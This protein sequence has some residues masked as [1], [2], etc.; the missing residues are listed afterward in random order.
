M[1]G[2][3]GD[4]GRE[5]RLLD[6]VDEG[7]GGANEERRTGTSARP[8]AKRA[9]GGTPLF[10][11]GSSA[12]SPVMTGGEEWRRGGGLKRQGMCVHI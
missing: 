9:A 1:Q 5:N 3:N 11:T 8:R 12:L 2:K 10:S 6:A 4:T 7:G